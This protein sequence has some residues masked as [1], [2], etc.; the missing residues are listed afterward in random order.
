MCLI[1]R[2]LHLGLSRHTRIMGTDT[3]VTTTIMAIR[4]MLMLDTTGGWE[5]GKGGRE[6]LRE[7][8]DEGGN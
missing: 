6:R 3:A 2:D 5:G 8:E 7:G 1:L 4:A